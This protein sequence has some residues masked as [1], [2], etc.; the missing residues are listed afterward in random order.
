MK[1]APWISAIV[2]AGLFFANFAAADTAVKLTEIF[3]DHKF[4]RPVALIT[5]PDDS[6]R[7]FFVE[8]TGKIKIIKGGKVAGEFLDFTDRKMAAKDFEEGLLGLAFHPKYKDNGKFYVFYTQQ[9]PKRSVISEIQVSKANAD[10]ADL[11]TERIL[12]EIHQPEWNHNGGNIMFGPKDGYLYIGSGDGGMRNGVH[13]LSQKLE[14]WQGKVLRIDVDNTSRGRQYAIP[15]DNPFVNTPHAAPEVYAYG[16]RNPWGI[17]IDDQT[18]DFWLADVGQNLWEEI[19]LIVPGGN[20]GWN[21]KEA[22]HTFVGYADLM[23]ALGINKTEPPKNLEMI[24][25][26]FEINRLEALSITGGYVYRGSGIPGLKDHFL[27]G[28]WKLGNMWALKKTGDNEASSQVILKPSPDEKIQPTGFY[29]D[30]N[31][32]PIVLNWDGRVFK[33]EAK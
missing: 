12:M 10:A 23:K 29:P 2:G 16:I 3:T 27:L 5:S 11:S 1:K 31:G 20:Y 28:D 24:E 22:S 14:V 26:V 30:L 6:S 9:G 19:N 33:M 17:W 15:S 18:N 8:Q 7:Q 21:Y 4:T 25:P 13:L 32:E